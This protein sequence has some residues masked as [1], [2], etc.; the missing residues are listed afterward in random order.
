MKVEN[1]CPSG[2][3]LYQDDLHVFRGTVMED[4]KRM[5][6]EMGVLNREHSQLISE[7]IDL[8]LY[9]LMI[10]AS[11]HAMASGVAITVVQKTAYTKKTRHRSTATVC[12][13]A[14]SCVL[15]TNTIGY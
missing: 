9:I 5:L 2:D 7:P 14:A 3:R 1:K 11:Y 13:N 15:N 6:E 4:K 8:I 10:S 12:P